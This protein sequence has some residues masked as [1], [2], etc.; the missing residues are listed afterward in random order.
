MV[1]RTLIAK[2]FPNPKRIRTAKG[3]SK[4]PAIMITPV[5]P[6]EGDQKSFRV[7]E[8]VKERKKVKVH[9]RLLL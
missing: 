3:G 2:S 7:K 8:L 1:Q 4:K 5:N 9:R 6:S